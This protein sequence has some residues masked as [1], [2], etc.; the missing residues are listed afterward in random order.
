MIL[1]K[2]HVHVYGSIIMFIVCLSMTCDYCVRNYLLYIFMIVMTGC[3]VC[4]WDIT[5]KDS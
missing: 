1:D 4:R 2:V 5:I 3:I